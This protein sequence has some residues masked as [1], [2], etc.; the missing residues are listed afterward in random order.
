MSKPARAAL[1]IAV[2]LACLVF[3]YD[4]SGPRP[5]FAEMGSGSVVAPAK[6][7]FLVATPKLAGSIFSETVILLIEYWPKGAQVV[8]INRPTH[9]L[10]SK[11]LPELKALSRIERVDYGGPVST[12]MLTF[13]LIKALTPPENSIQIFGGVYSL[14]NINDLKRIAGTGAQFRVYAGYSG[15]AGGQLESELAMG[16]WRVVHPDEDMIFSNEAA[17]ILKTDYDSVKEDAWPPRP[18]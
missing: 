16:S 18:L 11:V 4:I 2:F 17:G 12:N 1:A 3:V 13:A 15:W 5:L 7:K 10:V 9:L 14:L 8:I 6:G